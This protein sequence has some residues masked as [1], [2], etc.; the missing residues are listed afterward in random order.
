MC[1]FSYTIMTYLKNLEG[2]KSLNTKQFP[3]GLSPRIMRQ[4]SPFLP[5]CPLLWW[6]SV[7]PTRC[8]LSPLLSLSL[9][10]KIWGWGKILP[11][12]QKFTHFPTRKIFLHRL[13]YIFHYQ[14]YLSSLIKQQ[15]SCNHPMQALFVSAVISVVSFFNVRLYIHI[16]HA[17]LINQCLLNVAFSI[18]S[19]VKAING[20]S[21]SKQIPS[22]FQYYLK[23]PASSHSCFLLLHTPFF[24]LNLI[25]FQMT[26]L[27]L[28]FCGLC[29]NQIKCIPN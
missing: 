14:K 1:I 2:T 25:K 11:N 8:R 21:T 20:Q 27:H 10:G 26:P 12:S 19:M 18:T 17:I 7:A 5:K 9:Y 6:C 16:F 13:I 22:T 23:K 4:V 29:A 3:A 24:I 28:E 15:F